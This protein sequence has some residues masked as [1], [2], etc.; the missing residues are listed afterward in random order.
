MRKM[1]NILLALL[2]WTGMSCSNFL[3]M[4]IPDVLPD[5]EFWRSRSQLEAAR[6]GV[7]ERITR[8][9]R[10]LSTKNC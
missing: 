6:N 3:D 2:A 8:M 10:S 7:P 5:E 4:D 9:L 1:K